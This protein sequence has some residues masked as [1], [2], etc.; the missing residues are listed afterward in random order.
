MI[1]CKLLGIDKPVG[2]RK[3]GE[4]EI[5]EI[6]TLLFRPKMWLTEDIK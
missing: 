2:Y 3:G 6:T 1:N 5:D 4:A